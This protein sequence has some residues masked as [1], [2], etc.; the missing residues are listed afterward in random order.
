MPT[1]RQKRRGT[2]NARQ[3]DDPYAV[4]LAVEK[5]EIEVVLHG[6]SAEQAERIA[7]QKNRELGVETTV[8]VVPEEQLE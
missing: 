6:V 3:N 7:A 4:V 8:H 1:V 2:T 5:E